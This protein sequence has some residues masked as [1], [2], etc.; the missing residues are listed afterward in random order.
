VIRRILAAAVLFQTIALRAR[1]VLP[2]YERTNGVHMDEALQ[3]LRPTVQQST[4]RILDEQGQHILTGTFVTEDGYFLTKASEAPQ[5]ATLRVVLADETQRIARVVAR[6]LDQDLLL[7]RADV[8]SAQPVQWQATAAPLQ[9]GDWL[10]AGSAGVDENLRYTPIMRLGVVSAQPREVP[11]TR[12]AIGMELTD[13]PAAAGVTVTAVWPDS[14][15]ATAGITEGD[16]VL[17]VEEEA[18]RSAAQIREVLD[19]RRPGQSVSITLARG[20]RQLSVALRPGSYSRVSLTASGE[21]YANGG[22]SLRTDGYAAVIQ[23]DLPLK[24]R[25]MGS[26]LLNLEGKCVGINIARVDRISTYALPAD[27]LAKDLQSWIEQDRLDH[28]EIIRKATAVA[29]AE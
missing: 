10:V 5:A 4:L 20:K 8:S 21:D 1:E 11:A 6:S 2:I 18:I 7:A 12:A 17:S 24:T 9:L 14:P 22:V 28:P 19:T 16:Q 26:P 23:H 27:V 3:P 15:A 13:L 29:L 25:D